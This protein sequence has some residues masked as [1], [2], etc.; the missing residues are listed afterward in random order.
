M[1]HNTCKENLEDVRES[2]PDFRALEEK[3]ER[4]SILLYDV[5][6]NLRD[7][8]LN[9]K[10]LDFK[11]KVE[12][13]LQDLLTLTINGEK[14]DVEYENQFYKQQNVSLPTVN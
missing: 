5:C 10:E 7:V 2:L 3:H 12:Y 1:V 8:I 11:G 6:L 13:Y 4:I 9:N 14:R